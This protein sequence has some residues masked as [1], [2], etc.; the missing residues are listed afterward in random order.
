M[1]KDASAADAQAL[2]SQ[3]LDEHLDVVRT[4]RDSTGTISEIAGIITAALRSGGKVLTFGNGG[5]ATDAQH[6]VGELVGRYYLERKALPAVALTT[7]TSIITA[8][9][10]DYE[11]DRVFERQIEALGCPG[12][13]AVGISTSGHSRNVLRALRKAKD[14]GLSAVGMSGGDADEMETET[15]VCLRVQSSDTPRVQEAHITAIHIICEWVEREIAK[16]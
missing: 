16:Q 2:V 13:V 11:F 4:L 9:A 8:V 5:S 15:D 7:N 10:N 14:I 1:V 6:L 3:R 12:D